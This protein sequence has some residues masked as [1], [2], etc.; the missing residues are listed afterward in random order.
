[1]ENLENQQQK[2]V[3]FDIK[4]QK[5]QKLDEKTVETLQ[6]KFLVI[7]SGSYSTNIP[8]IMDNNWIKP[9]N[10]NSS[11]VSINVNLATLAFPYFMEQLKTWVDGSGYNTYFDQKTAITKWKLFLFKIESAFVKDG[12]YIFYTSDWSILTVNKDEFDRKWI[13]SPSLRFYWYGKK[14]DVFWNIDKNVYVNGLCAET[15]GDWFIRFSERWKYKFNIPWD[16][17]FQ[18]K[19]WIALISNEWVFHEYKLLDL[20]WKNDKLETFSLPYKWITQMAV[21]ENKNFLFVI[22]ETEEWSTLHILWYDAF[23]SKKQVYEI[24]MIKD[25]KQICGLWEDWMICLMTNWSIKSYWHTFSKFKKN[26]F[27]EWEDWTLAW[28][29][30]YPKDQ[31]VTVMTDNTKTDLLKSLE[32]GTISINLHQGEEDKTDKVDKDI[33]EKIWNLKIPTFEKTLRE[34]FN[35]ANDEDSMNQVLKLFHILQSNPEISKAWWLL[36]SIEK[37]I[38]DK[39]NKI[40]LNSIFSELWDITT[41]LWWDLDLQKLIS[42]KNKLYKIKWKR[43]NIQAWP[44]QQDNELKEL[45]VLVEQKIS[46][47]KEDHKEDFEGKIEDNLGKIQ[48]I[49]SSIDNAID[50]SSIY[51]NQIYQEI[52]EMI[53]CLDSAWQE[54]FKKSLKNLIDNRRREIKK[55]SEEEK[56]KESRNLEYKKKEVEEYINEIKD[57]LEDIDDISAVEQYKDNDTLVQKVKKLLEDLPSSVAQTLD[58]KLD[59]IF[60]ERIFTLRLN[61]EETKWVVQ[62]LDSYGIDTIL[63]YNEDWSEQVEWKIE[64]KEKPDWKIS[65]VVKLIN[66]ETHEYDKSLY[67]RDFEKY[68]DVTIRDWNIKFDMTEEEFSKYSRL[69]SKWKKTWK[70]EIKTLMEKIVK[71]TDI[72][73]KEQLQNDLKNKKEYYKDARYTELLIKRLIKQQKLNPRSKVPPF[74]P[75]FIVLDEEKEILKKIST[76]L[77][78]QKQNGGIDILE[79]WPGLWKTVMCEFLAQ[80]TNREII[81]VQCSKMDPSDMFFSPTLKKWET[82]REPADWI[83]L[84]QKPWTIILFDEID[85]LNDQCFERL[86][87]LFDRSRSVYDPQL[88][89]VKANS[90]CLFLWT[91][92]SYDRM[93]NPI[94]S[95]WRI[96]QVNYPWVL[97]ESY[98]VS[99]YT[100]SSILKK[101]SFEEFTQLYDKYITR[102][103]S[104]PSNARERKIYDLMKN[105]YHLLNVFTDLRSM[106]DSDEPFAFEISYRDARQIFVDYNSSWDF[107]KSMENILIPKARGAVIDPDD[108]KVQEEIVRNA[109]NKEIQ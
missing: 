108:K 68:W 28:K 4:E 26:F 90:D 100:D 65:L 77:I 91:R 63:Y 86:H 41:E 95:R 19:S 98:K 55:L 34:L 9:N 89:K 11:M 103:E 5:L 94:L 74:D 105:I 39:R 84:M 49:L 82:S 66:W 85:K 42:I 97:N 31:K 47:Y 76:R 72:E 83:K 29:L 43:K 10:Y 12:Q 44:I 60:G 32:D 23:I 71:E 107:K 7:I 62:N 37:E 25:V 53:S 8:S 78:D 69:L 109:I 33:I 16:N 48:D 59:R 38:I 54:K 67:L 20:E 96:L 1:M 46:D 50:I 106:Y 2:E 13:D 36:K 102:S 73:K 75:D 99:K 88:W 57:I 104:A 30:I 58:L 17:V 87:S 22:N 64:W 56:E 61:W 79:W 21:D 40:I 51:A 27:K 52:E 92:N 3:V 70:Q 15:T 80:V 6:Q 81:R 14:Q 35:E 93:S 18:I 24:S 101:M 45:I